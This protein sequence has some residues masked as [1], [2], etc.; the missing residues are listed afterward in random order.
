MGAKI[1]DNMEEYFV[2]K[3]TSYLEDVK[4]VMSELREEDKESQSI[5]RGENKEKMVAEND[6]QIMLKMML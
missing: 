1:E 5:V 6:A 3:E 4:E 2:A